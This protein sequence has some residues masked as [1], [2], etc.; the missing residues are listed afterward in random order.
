MDNMT[1]PNVTPADN[2]PHYERRLVRR[3]DDRVIAGVAAGL[4]DY[5]SVDPILF[6]VAFIVTSFTGGLGLLLYVVAWWLLPVGDPY[7]PMW[8]PPP[9]EG[10]LNRLRRRPAWLAVVLLIVGGALLVNAIGL[11][12]PAVVWGIALIGLGVLLFQQ[13][14]PD[15]VPAALG[16]TAPATAKATDPAAPAAFAATDV[17]APPAPPR[18]PKPRSHLGLFTLGA[19]LTVVG[20]TAVASSLGQVHLIASQFLA[21]ALAIVGAGLLVG[22]WWGRSRWL[23]VLGLLLVP[24]VL[25]ASLIDVPF[26]G[27]YGERLWTPRTSVDLRPAY[28]IVAGNARLDL[29][30]Y[31]FVS[32]SPIHIT[33][34]M[35]AGSLVVVLPSDVTVHAVAHVGVG[36]VNLFGRY[37]DGIDAG[38]TTAL[39]PF[40]SVGDVT[41]DARAGYGGIQVFRDVSN[42]GG[43]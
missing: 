16:P 24:V 18:P 11:W 2:E 34:S 37:R 22:A 40:K 32:S 29:T 8:R 28:R 9:G 30:Q 12:R 35:V 5:F 36:E 10:L 26:Q 7:D 41:I 39:E 15:P 17:Q 4:G 13:P 19:L 3:T 23:I 25:L 1:D 42:G 31:P 21:L 20:A 27:G 43:Q 14:R 38:L 6:R 33:V